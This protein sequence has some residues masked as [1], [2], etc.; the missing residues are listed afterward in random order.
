L[1]YFDFIIQNIKGETSM[2]T[3]KESGSLKGQK[4]I[5]ELRQKPEGLLN[6]K[7]RSELVFT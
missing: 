4:K 2:S 5:L 7:K 3:F 6:K 1:D